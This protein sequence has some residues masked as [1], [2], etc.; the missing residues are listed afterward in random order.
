ML[1]MNVR[2][3]P[4]HNTDQGPSSNPLAEQLHVYLP[5]NLERYPPLH[6]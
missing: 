3:R 6:S 2:F 4:L 1:I 5:I